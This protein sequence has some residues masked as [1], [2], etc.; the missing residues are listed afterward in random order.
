THAS[1]S[2]SPHRRFPARTAPTPSPQ[3][4][5]FAPRDIAVRRLVN[6]GVEPIVVAKTLAIGDRDGGPEQLSDLPVATVEVRHGSAR[7]SNE[8][9]ACSRGIAAG[10]GPDAPRHAAAR[11]SPRLPVPP[12]DPPP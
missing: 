1:A 6:A 3:R 8:G 2:R 9:S 12:K 11:L 10:G 4:S 5:S 7:R